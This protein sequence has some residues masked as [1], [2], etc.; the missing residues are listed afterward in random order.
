MYRFHLSGKISDIK[1]NK[2]LIV[3]YAA[4]TALAVST[5]FPAYINSSFIENFVDTKY[6]GLFFVAANIVTFFAML[7]FPALIRKLSNLMSAKLMMLVNIVS[8]MVLMMSPAPIWLFLFFI[9]MWVSSNL[10]WINMDIFVESFTEN[11]NTGKIRAFYFTFM[12]LG[13]ILTPILASK[14]VIGNDYYNLVYLAAAFVFLFFYFIIVF[15]E[16]RV[17]KLVN[18]D[19]LKIKD[20]IVD[21]WKNANL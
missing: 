2:N 8:L 7:F 16:K 14:L 3:L 20:V 15:N 4:G 13:W 5:A 6:V 9:C 11:A 12:N 21:F 10:I 19:K 1:F 17:G 18:F